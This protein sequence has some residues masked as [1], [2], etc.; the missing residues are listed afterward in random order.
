MSATCEIGVVIQGPTLYYKT[1][2]EKYGGYK[3]LVWSTW[4][5]EPTENIAGI[6][7][8]GMDI[9]L[10]SKPEFTGSWNAILQCVSTVNGVKYLK[11]K[12]PELNLFVKVRSDLVIEPFDGLIRSVKSSLKKS[13]LCSSGYFIKPQ[14]LSFSSDYFMMDFVVGGTYESH[15]K[16]FSVP[17]VKTAGLPFPEKWL[18]TNYF[19]SSNYIKS[20]ITALRQKNFF[21]NWDGIRYTFLK[22]I[23]SLQPYRFINGH[24]VYKSGIKERINYFFVSI[25]IRLRRM[26]GINNK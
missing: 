26:L 13:E 24:M 19:G 12:Y 9:L 1:I 4:N 8:G 7:Y 23:L 20:N 11:E 5:D 3:Y 14:K 6:K 18:E 21:I 16:F 22:E 15:I 17:D 25:R 10:N 2:L